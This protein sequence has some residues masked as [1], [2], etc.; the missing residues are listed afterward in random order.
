MG[1][2]L[3]VEFIYVKA[4]TYPQKQCVHQIHYQ[5]ILFVQNS[6]NHLHRL[7][8]LHNYIILVFLRYYKK[9]KTPM[10]WRTARLSSN[11]QPCI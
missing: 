4:L 7:L 3:S 5:L 11:N 8:C 10:S 6:L 9:Q 1:C 2:Y